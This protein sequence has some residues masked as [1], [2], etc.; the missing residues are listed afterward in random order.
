MDAQVQGLIEV[1][2]GPRHSI[3]FEPLTTKQLLKNFTQN[4]FAIV[5][6]GKCIFKEFFKILLIYFGA[7]VH[8]GPKASV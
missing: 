6:E 1:A 2:W 4:I 5:L 8:S 7:L 3:Y